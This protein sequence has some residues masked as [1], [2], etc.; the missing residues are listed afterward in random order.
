MKKV[1][2]LM[3]PKNIET[4]QKFNLIEKRLKAIEGNSLIKGIDAFEISLVLNVVIPQKLKMP[5]F[6]RYSGSSRPRAD[7]TIF[8]RKMVGHTAAS[9]VFKRA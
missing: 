6:V 3:Q 1:E 8:C 5:D 7:M 9:I 2:L 4:Q